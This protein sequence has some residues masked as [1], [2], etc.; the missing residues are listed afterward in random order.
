MTQ[1]EEKRLMYDVRYTIDKCIEN[2]PLRRKEDAMYV[3]GLK[4]AVDLMEQIAQTYV[5]K[6]LKLR[7]ED[8][9]KH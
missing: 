2:T 9:T 1:L 7:H 4:D 5:D 6:D 8:K 3:S